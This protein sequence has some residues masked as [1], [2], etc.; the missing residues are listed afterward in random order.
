MSKIFQK[1]AGEGERNFLWAKNHMGGL[2]VLAEKYA[3]TRPLERLKI[4]VCLH[5][6]KETSV[7]IASLVKA[8]ANVTLA[9]A[10]PLSTQDDVAAYLAAEAEV[11][12]WRGGR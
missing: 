5:V 12:A 8:W 7:L 1:L 6:T 10:N 11:Y 2:A 9:A 4:G 3:K